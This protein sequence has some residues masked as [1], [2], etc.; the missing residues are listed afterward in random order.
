MDRLGVCWGRF[1][2]IGGVLGAFAG[3]LGGACAVSGLSL[4]RGGVDFERC[5]IPR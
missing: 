2:R 1:W 4:S 5:S 3:R